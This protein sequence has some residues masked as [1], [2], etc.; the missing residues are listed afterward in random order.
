MVPKAL[1]EYDWDL[2]RYLRRMWEERHNHRLFYQS[3]RWRALRQRV[4][5]EHHFESWDERHASPARYVRAT[6]V[7]HDRYVFSYP[8]WALSEWWVDADGTVH[9]NLFPLSHEAHD[10]RH[11]R[12][13]FAKREPRFELTKE[14]W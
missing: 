1:P 5:E 6:C 11:N 2:D 10:A 8:G 3:A 4:L 12:N 13:S 9:R 7:H 14:M